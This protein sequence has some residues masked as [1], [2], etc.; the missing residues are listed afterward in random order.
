MRFDSTGIRERLRQFW[1][2]PA[3]F[4]MERKPLYVYLMNIVRDRRVLVR[5]FNILHDELDL[6]TVRGDGPMY[7]AGADFS[8]PCVL[9]TMAHTNCGD[10]IHQ[11]ETMTAYENIVGRR[12]ATMNELG[13]VKEEK[14]FPTGGGADSGPTLAHV[15][16]AHAI[17]SDI[18]RALYEGNPRSFMLAGFD[19]QTHVGR[20][21]TG[22]STVFGKTPESDY[23]QPRAS[24]GA[25]VG[26][27]TGYDPSNIVH[28]RLRAD[29][30][31][32][33]FSYLTKSR[34]VT[35]DG[36]DITCLVAASIV[37]VQGM[38][39]TIDALTHEL[40][41]RGMAHLTASVAINRPSKDDTIV[42]L[43][44]ATVAD[45]SV[46]VQGFGTDA[47]KYG[48]R[49]V[50]HDGDRRI[51]LTY[52]GLE[53]ESFKAETRHYTPTAAPAH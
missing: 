13:E 40:D 29:L 23:R 16:I 38:Y 34:I 20:L 28:Q 9:T 26:A 27:L 3:Q 19:I 49:M 32:E 15:T 37:A 35:K 4:G 33:S 14:F 12:F 44:R 17:D 52:D 24:C 51:L 39:N 2:S 50:D 48:G 1:E 46:K 7:A 5:G 22:S 47:R 43:S 45:G 11:G 42:Y 31:E 10:R 6:A 8:A 36:V 30:G 41:E 21:D 25:I 53:L 18:R